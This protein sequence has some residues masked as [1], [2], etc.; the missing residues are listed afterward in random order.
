MSARRPRAH[1]ESAVN[2]FEV[3]AAPLSTEPGW[4]LHTATVP[5]RARSLL[6]MCAA[7]A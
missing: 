5:L 6:S 3:Q 7:V 4:S 1:S 2:A